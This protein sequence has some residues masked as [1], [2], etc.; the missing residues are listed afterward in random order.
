MICYKIENLICNDLFFVLF[1][2]LVDYINHKIN[3]F[4]IEYQTIWLDYRI[5]L[6]AFLME[7]QVFI[8][9]YIIF[10]EVA[11]FSFEKMFTQSYEFIRGL[12]AAVT[13]SDKGII[14]GIAIEFTLFILVLLF[15]YKIYV[16]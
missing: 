11:N 2:C 16:L 13:W 6:F 8:I 4:K 5:F 14:A 7:Q 10:Q 1:R 15:R 3:L 12:I 9:S